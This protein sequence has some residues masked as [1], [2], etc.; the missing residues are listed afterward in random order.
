LSEILEE[1][2]TTCYAW[3]LIPNHFHLLLRSGSVPISTVMRGLLTAPPIFP[4]V[5]LLPYRSVRPVS[6]ADHQKIT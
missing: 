4:C 6:Q 1:T 3:A 5:P 2:K